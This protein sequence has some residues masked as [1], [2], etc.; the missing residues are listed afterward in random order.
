LVYGKKI[1]I[2]KKGIDN[3]V[4]KGMEVYLEKGS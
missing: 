2:E 4:R 1:L 3:E